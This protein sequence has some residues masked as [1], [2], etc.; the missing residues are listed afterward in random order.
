[1]VGAFHDPPDLT[2]FENLPA[3]PRWL[4]DETLFS[5]ASRYHALSG[6]RLPSTT[7]RVLFGHSRQGCQH[8]FPTRLDEFTKRTQLSDSPRHLALRHT[9][10][11][12]YLPLRSEVDSEA[13]LHSLVI[14]QAGILKFRLGILTSRFRANHPLKACLHCIEDD[15]RSHGVGYWHVQQQLPGVWVCRRHGGMLR[16]SRLK[17]SGVAR[18]GWLLPTSDHLDQIAHPSGR[19]KCDEALESFANLVCAWASLPVQTHF[20]AEQLALTYRRALGTKEMPQGKASRSMAAFAPDLRAAVAP[21]RHVPELS[22]LPATVQHASGLLDRCVKRPRG[23]THPLNHLAIIHWLFSSWDAFL[24]CYAMDSALT[25]EKPPPAVLSFQIP[26]DSRQAALLEL[27]GQGRSISAA[28]EKVGIDTHTA[29]AWAARAGIATPRRPK[30]LKGQAFDDLVAA[31]RN[32]MDKADAARMFSVSVQTVTRVLRSVVGL[33]SA[34]HV[35]RKASAREEARTAWSAAVMQKPGVGVKA[36]RDIAPRAYAWLYRNDRDWLREA[37]AP[38]AHTRVVMTAPRIDWDARD[39]VL[40]AD[41]RRVAAEIA[42]KAGK[43]KLALWEIY[44]VLPELK[45]K[46]GALHRLPLTSRAITEAT[47]RRMS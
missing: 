5:L 38:A 24:T 36:V 20:T 28:A 1:M 43:S 10:L 18:F 16:I 37:S 47:H 11:P 29:A 27:L 44:Q 34:W 46:L 39:R 3:M 15:V 19:A 4:P 42:E 32:G 25:P 31:L 30:V 2:G 40:S 33:Q 13:V 7:C 12:F 26:S 22:A 35:N 23:G 45:A 9:L 41:V 6:N 17:S 14:P 21:L 8:D